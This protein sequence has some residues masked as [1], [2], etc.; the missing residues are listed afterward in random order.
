MLQYNGKV[1]TRNK[2]TGAWFDA[3]NMRVH[4]ALQH[5]L[6]GLYKQKQKE[7]EERE[8]AALPGAEEPDAFV[9]TEPPLKDNPLCIT[10]EGGRAYFGRYPQGLDGTVEPIRW[11]V[12]YEDSE[13]MFST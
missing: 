9:I 5:T 4:V 11:M 3:D 12:I 10:S 7:I 2:S 13:K 6:D 8:A 1:Y